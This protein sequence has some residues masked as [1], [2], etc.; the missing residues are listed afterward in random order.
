M[1]LFC[2]DLDNTLIYSWK[3]EIGC[4]KRCVEIYQEREIS[5][6][7]DTTYRLL[8]KVKD[9]VSIVPTTTRTVEQ[10]Q[11]IDLGIGTLDYALMCNGGVLFLHGKE[12]I[13]WY[14]ETKELVAESRKELAF[15]EELLL[16]DKNR[17][18]EVRNIRELFLFTK[19]SNPKASA[20]CLKER[21]DGE[22]AQVFCNGNKV[23]IVPIQLNKGSALLRLKK[24]LQ[25]ELVIAAGDS[26]FDIPML[27]QADFAVAPAELKGAEGISERVYFTNEKMLFSE[28]LLKKIPDFTK[29]KGK[30]ADK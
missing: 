24:R 10:Y 29:E 12:D 9:M 22:K 13:S 28:A 17:C 5:F 30:T 27:N 11:R 7:T 4:K 16:K 21:I 20:A 19:S 6:M 2:C 15:G 14:E 23:Y 1:I 26:G 18:F 8:N 25:A 3:H